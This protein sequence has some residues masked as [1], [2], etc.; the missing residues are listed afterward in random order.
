MRAP[1]AEDSLPNISVV[2]LPIPPA[3]ATP[4]E[5]GPGHTHLGP[6]FAYML[7]GEIE[8]Q[9]EPDPS[10]F[11][12]PGGFFY[13]APGHV[14]RF[15]RNLS[16]T[17]GA[18]L[19][20]FQEGADMSKANP[21]IKLLLQVPLPA[22]ANREVSLFRLTLAGGALTEARAHSGPGIVYV[23][24]GKI[25][26]SGTTDQPGI[27]SAGD[28]FVEPVS[29]AGLTFRNASSIEPV[30]LL[31]YQVNEKGERGATP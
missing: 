1:V 8:N 30:K 27:H 16:T 29:R 26:I 23:L 14:H 28:L 24:E 20:V 3:P 2:S 21:A 31:W 5:G 19:I 18:S 17:E 10:A 12:K 25:E 22:T 4:R 9:V 7:Q 11:Y 13:E 15:L 6:V